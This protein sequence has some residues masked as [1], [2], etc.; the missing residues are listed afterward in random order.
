[1][2]AVCK[3]APILESIVEKHDVK[4]YLLFTG[5]N[6]ENDESGLVAKHFI[7][8]YQNAGA[9]MAVKAMHLWYGTKGKS[10]EQLQTLYPRNGAPTKAEENQLDDM[11]HWNTAADITH[12]PTIYMNGHRLPE[13]YTLAQLQNMFDYV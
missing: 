5:T 7:A 4:M 12:T 9:E 13:Q 6:N 8:L 10:W 11:H 3:G 1:M 2:R